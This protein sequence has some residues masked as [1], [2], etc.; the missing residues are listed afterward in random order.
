M[1][2]TA[3]PALARFL[4]ACYVLSDL[5]DEALREL[6]GDSPTSAIVAVGGYG[7]RTQ[8]RH[9]DVDVMLLID[10]SEEG[11]LRAL[12]P[13][14]DANLKVGH[15]VRTV[16]QAMVAADANLETFTALLDA[17]FVGG[18]R[19]LY[20]TR[21]LR[22]VHGALNERGTVVYWSAANEDAFEQ[23]MRKEGFTTK[24]ERVR[25]Y[26]TG[27]PFHTLLLGRRS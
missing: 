8:S 14:W 26:G 16:P 12:Y 25:A 21:G 2:T 10:G 7:R 13:L 24:V 23:L 5:L 15:S 6:A 17:R 22:V 1:A 4:E 27:G 20:E 9:S 19:A 11:A 3:H 18:N